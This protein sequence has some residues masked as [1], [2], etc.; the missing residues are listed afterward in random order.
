MNHYLRL[1]VYVCAV[2]CHVKCISYLGSVFE[3]FNKYY[4]VLDFE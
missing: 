4:L 3:M 2:I 1:C